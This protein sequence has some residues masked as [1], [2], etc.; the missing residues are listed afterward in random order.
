LAETRLRLSEAEQEKEL[1]FNKLSQLD[2]FFDDIN[3]RE[4]ANLE[5]KPLLEEIMAQVNSIL[6]QQEGGVQ[7]ARGGS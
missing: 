3:S 2:A 7:P 6:F 4:G 5:H 1:Y